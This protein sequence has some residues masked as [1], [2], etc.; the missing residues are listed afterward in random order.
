MPSHFI[1][2][3]GKVVSCFF[4]P[5]Y[6]TLY[7]NTLGVPGLGEDIVEVTYGKQRPP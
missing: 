7:P 2:P 4:D 5:L 1:H 3:G 6:L